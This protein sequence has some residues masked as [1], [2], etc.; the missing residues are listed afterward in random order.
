MLLLR[1]LQK[2]IATLNSEGTPGQVAAGIA[3]GSIFG[4]TPFMNLHNMLMF[5]GIALFNVSFPAAM[6]GWI[7]FE[8]IGFF[9]DPVFD[10]LGSAMLMRTPDLVPTW[11]TLYNL[12]IVPLSNYNNTVVLGSL[13][14][15]LALCIP[16]FF[17]ARIGV[18]R[19]REVVLSRLKKT[20]IYQ[21]VKASKIYNLYRL[22]RPE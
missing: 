5:A 7:I 17:V 14:G 9:L 4:L 18:A 3:L 19:Y 8:P 13:V 15:W 6:L 11:T 21:M 12:P 22:F 2:L 10:S 16:I 20:K 1:L